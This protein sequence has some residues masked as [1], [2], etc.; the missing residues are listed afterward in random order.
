[1]KKEILITAVLMAMGGMMNDIS[2]HDV[3]QLILL[4]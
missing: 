4:Q 1:M 3:Y 2:A